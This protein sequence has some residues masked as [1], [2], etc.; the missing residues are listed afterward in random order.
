MRKTTLRLE[1]LDEDWPKD[2]TRIQRAIMRHGYAC[3]RAEAQELWSLYSDGMCAG[4][5]GLPET[6]DHIWAC[7]KGYIIGEQ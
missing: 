4:W 2:V 7:V 6:D 3:S 1:R 5:L